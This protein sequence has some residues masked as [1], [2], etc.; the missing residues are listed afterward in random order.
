[1][2]GPGHEGPL[3]PREEQQL[4]E[5]LLAGDDAA[6]RALYG[7]FGRPVYTMGLRLL[8]SREAA[9]EL[10]QDVFLTAWRKA[11]RFD[12]QRGRLSTWLMTIAHN[13]AVDRL[14]RDTGVSRPHLVLV[15]EVPDRPA[16]D[17]EYALIE[18]DEALRALAC[19]SDAEKRLI[20]RAYFRGMTAREIAE[21]DAIP[22][23]TVK[24]RLRSA[25]I[26]IRKANELKEPS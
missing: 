11:A 1:M 14:R 9:E 19:L 26:K 12:P 3:L 6:I 15:D 4:M 7:R 24:T 2:Q 22:L 5:G 18:R 10:T 25:L 8:G 20:A 17:E 13:L 16:G 23:G 21:A